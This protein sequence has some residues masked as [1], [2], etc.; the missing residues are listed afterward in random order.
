MFKSH[1]DMLGTGQFSDQVLTVVA[2]TENNE[3]VVRNINVHKIVLAGGSPVFERMIFGCS[4][5]QVEVHIHED[6]FVL[7]Y[8]F[9]EAIYSRGQSI[10]FSC[11][12]TLEIVRLITIAHR[13]MAEDIVN[14]CAVKLIPEQICHETFEVFNLACMYDIE[15]LKN[16]C[17][18]F[19]QEHVKDF[20]AHEG[21][22]YLT[23]DA[24]NT[25]LQLEVLKIDTVIEIFNA[26]VRWA[27]N[28]LYDSECHMDEDDSSLRDSNVFCSTIEA[29][30]S[31]EQVQM[32]T[33]D[34]P[35]PDSGIHST[36]TFHNLSANNSK[37]IQN[38]TG[39]RNFKKESVAE[40][41]M[42]DWS[43]EEKKI[44]PNYGNK[45]R[46]ILKNSG[47][48]KR[49]RFCT[50]SPVDF[51]THVVPKQIL[52]KYEVSIIFL[53]INMLTKSESGWGS[54]LIDG[55]ISRNK[56]YLTDICLNSTSQIIEARSLECTTGVLTFDFH[57]RFWKRKSSFGFTTETFQCSSKVPIVI[58]GVIMP[59]KCKLT[60]RI[61]ARYEEGITIHIYKTSSESKAGEV[62][63]ECNQKVRRPY[64]S[65]FEYPIKYSLHESPRVLYE[66]QLFTVLIK[67]HKR[68]DYYGGIGYRETS[69]NNDIIS[70]SPKKQFGIIQGFRYRTIV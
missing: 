18:K 12:T 46:E 55:L 11:L 45:I 70:V 16:K 28:I 58:E 7:F 65:N 47:V 66:G 36:T 56:N 10:D 20:F 5:Y 2:V 32:D 30:C 44:D 13:Y 60:K 69:I 63:A 35:D 4:S 48:L 6:E 52:N 1:L 38:F 62:I 25:I 14:I 54:R 64:G 43:P 67:F 33:S 49:I 40:S 3:K 29:R 53:V 23:S 17:I 61:G 51:G 42:M 41:T 22:I 68:G 57:N 37:P 27:E 50:M 15:E 21:F 19:F 34:T 39:Y 59:P 24:L 9:L 8:K 31:S 26:V